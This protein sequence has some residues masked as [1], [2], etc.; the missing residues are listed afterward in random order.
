MLDEDPWRIWV[1]VKVAQVPQADL[2]VKTAGYGLLTVVE[3]ADR[4]NGRRVHEGE[5]HVALR[6]GAICRQ[7]PKDDL[8][9]RV[10]GK[11]PVVVDERQGGDR[12]AVGIDDDVLI[13]VAH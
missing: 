8:T 7:I 5:H 9:I 13:P 2:T 10:A 6:C 12:I 1:G 3:D 4:V 11:E